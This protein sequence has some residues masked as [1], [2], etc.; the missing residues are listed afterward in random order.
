MTQ[1]FD[2]LAAVKVVAVEVSGTVV[3][4]TV[5]VVEAVHVI[6]HVVRSKR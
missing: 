2:V 4:I 1:L 5:V 3:F 6:T